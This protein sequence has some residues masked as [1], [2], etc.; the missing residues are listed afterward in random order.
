M[1]C[2]VCGSKMK[3]TITDLPLKP[4]TRNFKDTKS[5]TY[6]WQIEGLE[7]NIKEFYVNHDGEIS[8]VNENGIYKLTFE[9]N[10]DKLIVR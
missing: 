5:L 2:H 8:I 9:V 6:L 3:S 1:K 10:D 7:Y 4:N